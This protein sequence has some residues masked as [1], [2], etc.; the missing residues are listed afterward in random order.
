MLGLP[1]GTAPSGVVI[2]ATLRLLMRRKLLLPARSSYEVGR[3]ESRCGSSIQEEKILDIN[4][5]TAKS[6]R[7][8]QVQAGF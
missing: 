3:G 6:R 4:E 1:S 8:T 5:E 2:A 7:H